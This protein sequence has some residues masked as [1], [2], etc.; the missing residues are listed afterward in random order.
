MDKVLLIITK[1]FEIGGEID[2]YQRHLR[3]ALEN[4]S[5]MPRPFQV[6]DVQMSLN[7]GYYRSALSTV[8][9]VVLSHGGLLRSFWAA[10][11]DVDLSSTDLS[12]LIARSMP[13]IDAIIVIGGD[14]TMVGA[15]RVAAASRMLP[16]LIGINAGHL[17]FITDLSLKTPMSAVF[18]LL[19]GGGITERRALLTCYN[20]K[21]QPDTFLAMNDV[22]IKSMNGRIVSFSLYIDE[23]FAY[24][25]RADGLL[26]TTP[27]GS[28]AY[29]ASAGGSLL[30]P[31]AKVVGITPLMPQS[32]SHRSIVIPDSANITV[33]LDSGA[34]GI[35]LDGNR[36]E[37]LEASNMIFIR[38]ALTNVTFCHPAD[39][40]FLKTL[41]EK[42]NWQLEPGRT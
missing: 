10:A 12:I 26:I 19:R 30:D 32:L 42:L 24:S 14:G 5:F 22:V 11:V 16:H 15:A 21:T 38:R 1:Q 29:N 2:A 33:K 36:V 40:D 31:T 4:R 23:T 17:G 13:P 41:R 28:T 35:F 39:Y 8:D 6:V 25:C 3:E 9:N 37:L 7:N 18:D 27:T 20:E 34:A